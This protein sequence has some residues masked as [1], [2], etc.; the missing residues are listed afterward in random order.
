MHF[1]D[2]P[3]R[4]RKADAYVDLLGLVHK[5]R[6][7]VAGRVHQRTLGSCCVDVPPV[8]TCFFRVMQFSW[9]TC[10]RIFAKFIQAAHEAH[11]PDQVETL[12]TELRFVQVALGKMGERIPVACKRPRILQS[13]H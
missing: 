8:L 11:Q 3:S 9:Y 13:V 2:E 1:S 6:P 10:G 7:G 12:K 5:F 4:R